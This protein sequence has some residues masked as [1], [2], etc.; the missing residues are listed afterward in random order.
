MLNLGNEELALLAIWSEYISSAVVFKYAD[1]EQIKHEWVEQENE[2]NGKERA[3]TE[4]TESCKAAWVI[5][6][7]DFYLD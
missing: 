2:K 7:D 3:K 5:R 6:Q 4:Q 1:V